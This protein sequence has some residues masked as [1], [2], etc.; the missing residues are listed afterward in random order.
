MAQKAS[1]VGSVVRCR[2]I[3]FE[4]SAAMGGICLVAIF[5]GTTFALVVEKSDSAV[6]FSPI[7]YNDAG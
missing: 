3:R 7:L 6:T 1:S 4:F 5:S 2:R